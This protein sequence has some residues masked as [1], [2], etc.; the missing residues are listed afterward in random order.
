MRVRA[1]LIDGQPVPGGDQLGHRPADVGIEVIPHDYQ[2]A[3]EL[4]VG[5]VQA[6]VL[7]AVLSPQFAGM[8]QIGIT[9]PQ[10]GPGNAVPLQ[11]QMNGVTTTD[12]LQ[13]AVGL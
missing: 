3:G 9:V 4:L 1:Q 12:Q 7:Y 10:V 11:I 8:Y 2:R 6:N 13:I 5:G